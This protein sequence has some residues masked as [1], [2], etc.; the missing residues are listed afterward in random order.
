MWKR[1]P[2]EKRLRLRGKVW[3]FWGYD[4]AGKR[5]E[6]TTHQT[7]RKHAIDAAR[8][9]EED[10]RRQPVSEADQTANAAAQ[11]SLVDALN[12]L[13][14]HDK[15]VGA[16]KNTVA[17]HSACGRHLVR[18]FGKD[19]LIAGFAGSGGLALLQSYSDKRL[20]EKAHRHTIQ[21]EHRVL[22]HSL[23]LAADVGLFAGDP[24]KLKV[25]GFTRAKGKRG[26]YQPGRTWLQNA[27][28]VEA[29]LRHT[30]IN[31]ARNRV[32]RLDD[33]LCYVNLGVRRRELLKIRPE[34]VD[35]A[36]RTVLVMGTKTDG[37]ERTLPLNRRMVEVFTRRVQGAPPGRPLFV[38]WGSGNRD[39]KSNW[40]RARA[41]LVTPEEG[42]SPHILEEK[43][44]L[45]TTLP[46]S[47]NFNDL[48]RTFC[49]LMKNAGVSFEDCAE[50]LGHEDIEMVR[51]VYGLTAMDSKRAAVE[52]LPDV[53]VPERKPREP[54]KAKRRAKA[55]VM[56]V[57]QTVAPD[58]PQ[59]LN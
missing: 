25:E 35:L 34:H 17:F 19:A 26:Y 6:V 13:R 37:A 21:K 41:E 50:L 40:R 51:L 27:E 33:T 24:R 14:A 46:K 38:E 49:S 42:D 28:Q 5:Y 32:D 1:S 57:A 45:D 12:L 20:E 22:R 3:F 7:D 55:R 29:L 18:L 44:R 11:T 16:A 30:S 36:A 4:W 15:R 8:R 47:L 2:L 54:R 43:A 58:L 48:R 52:K 56:F 59:T 10:R 53:V 9:I 23:R 39:L 31:S